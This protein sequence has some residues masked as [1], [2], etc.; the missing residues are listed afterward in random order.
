MLTTTSTQVFAW[1]FGSGRVREWCLPMNKTPFAFAFFAFLLICV[2]RIPAATA[3]EMVDSEQEKAFSQVQ[4]EKSYRF[5]FEGNRKLS[6]RELR[7]AGF[8]ELNN[9]ICCGRAPAAVDDAAFLMKGAYL[10]QGFHFARVE[11]EIVADSRE[12]RVTF[13]VEE[14]PQVLIDEI[15]LD[16]CRSFAAKDLLQ[17]LQGYKN[18]EGRGMLFVESDL[19]DLAGQIYSHYFSRGY[20]DVKVS[21]PE[22]RF[23]EG[24]RKAAV[25][26]RLQEG[27]QFLIAAVEYGGDIIDGV[28]DEL[29]Q[30]ANDLSGVPYYPRRKLMLQSKIQEAYADLGY[31]DATIDV[32]AD[33]D[34][35]SGRIVLQVAIHSGPRVSVS[36][37]EVSG[38]ERTDRDFVLSRLRLAGGDTF[39]VQKKRESF[40]RL[41]QTGLFSRVA[42][43]LEADRGEQQRVLHVDV[44][45]KPAREFY[46]EP[47]WGSYELLR[48]KSGYRD[49]NFSGAGRILKAEGTASFK[50]RALETGLTDPWFLGRDLVADVPF[51]YRNREEPSFVSEE[52]GSAFLL[53]KKITRH[54]SLSSGYSYKR[55]TIT[56]VDLFTGDE[57][58]SEDYTLATLSLQATADTRDDLFFPSKGYRLHAMI[59]L[60][61]S[62]WGSNLEFV[63]LTGGMRCFFPVSGK[64]TLGLRYATGFVMPVGR[65]DGIPIG[66]RFFNGGENTVRSFRESELGPKD[67]ANEPF[68]GMAFNTINIELRRKFG[69]SFSGSFFVDF[70]N[71][72]PSWI[73]DCRQ[74]PFPSDRGE[75][76]SEMF[77]QYFRDMRAG[78]GAGVQ[79]LLPIGPA[80]LDVAYNPAR[81][82]SDEDAMLLHFSI[83]MAF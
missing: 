69:E 47:G 67:A 37:I 64:V 9:Y 32:I 78:I 16:G 80:R 68:G 59:E 63:R 46:L 38:N 24:S 76:V 55:K 52:V 66:E 11:Y 12:D 79:Y 40:S 35:I 19:H 20:I 54:I 43:D 23:N 26:I 77:G 60:A 6:D 36:E 30:A 7:N 27:L 29:D 8:I 49:R 73:S 65:Q 83:G 61:D 10:R 72:A 28:R 21:A 56:N 17:Y 62:F 75:L 45:E 50:S 2:I 13:T 15:V 70:G 81:E 41:Y 5:F 33:K 82:N 71:I 48:I 4:G 44:E 34:D 31:P 14:G 25:S 1:F 22:T 57:E 74:T 3:E 58:D 39:S 53:S 51:Y 42:V 18:G